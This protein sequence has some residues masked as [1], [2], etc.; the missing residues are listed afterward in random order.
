MKKVKDAWTGNL[1]PKGYMVM[2]WSVGFGQFKIE[3]VCR[4]AF[5]NCYD[6]SHATVD[7]CCTSIK[8]GSMVYINNFYNDK[9]NSV[10]SK[11]EDSIKQNA[12][13]KYMRIHNFTMSVEQ[14]A[15]CKIPNNEV[16]LNAYGWMF[17][18][19]N[20]VGDIQPNKQD[21]IHLEPCTVTSVYLEYLNDLTLQYNHNGLITALTA[22]EKQS[23]TS[24]PHLSFTAFANFWNQYFPHVSIREFKAV[25][26]KCNVCGKLSDLRKTAMSRLMKQEITTL[27]AF[28]RSAYM[29]ERMAYAKRKFD[30]LNYSSIYLSVI[31]DGMAQ[32]HCELPYGANLAQFSS[33]F[34]QHIQGVLLH[35]RGILIYRTFNTISNCANLQIHTMLLTLQH[36]KNTENQIPGVFYYQIDGGSENTAKAVI[37]LC[38]YL[39]SKRLVI[40]IVL[41][42][43][44]V[45][46]THEDIDGKFGTV[47]TYTREKSILTPDAYKRALYKCLKKKDSNDYVCVVDLIAIPD[48]KS[49][50]E[51]CIDPKFERY[52]KE[53]QTQRQ[54]IFEACD[55]SDNF[56][57]GVRTMYR[58]YAANNVIEIIDDP[59]EDVKL[60]AVCVEVSSFPTAESSGSIVDGM[61]ILQKIPAAELFPF[62]FAKP[63]KNET[64][65]RQPIIKTMNAVE[66]YLGV[67]SRQKKDEWLD[68][69]EMFPE[70]NENV[71]EYIKRLQ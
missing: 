29:N 60:R 4:T 46:H 2:K 59:N 21:E 42:R 36:V 64:N 10:L 61:Y 1:T 15:A 18:Y 20:L 47:W 57:L 58:A 41:T 69:I 23:K 33:K 28:H 7:R 62:E 8:N 50:F 55:I 16:N 35:G 25:S 34:G 31:T 6:L 38:E 49:F 51:P 17:H 65:L 32:A 68:F 24:Y 27:H 43:L 53:D 45:G 71:H 5:L 67:N 40:K 14:I 63:A 30:A 56:P 48:Y 39:V 44:M 66:R 52:C 37:A 3:K 19:F 12:L 54:F 9:T 22:E 13:I 11:T 26:G 70:G